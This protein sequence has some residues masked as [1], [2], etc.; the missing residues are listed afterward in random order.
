M[1]TCLAT[2]GIKNVRYFE[3]ILLSISYSLL[4]S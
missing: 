4:F 1:K 2:E 3:H